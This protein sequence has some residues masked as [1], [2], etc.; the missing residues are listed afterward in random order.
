MRASKNLP[1]R[2][3]GGPPSARCPLSPQEI[4]DKMAVQAATVARIDEMRDARRSEGRHTVYERPG[5]RG[6][7][8]GGRG[9]GGIRDGD[10]RRPLIGYTAED[11]GFTDEGCRGPNR[12]LP[13]PCSIPGFF[14]THGAS[15]T[16]SPP[17]VLVENVVLSDAGC[18]VPTRSSSS[19]IRHP[20]SPPSSLP[21]HPAP[22]G[23]WGRVP[24]RRGAGRHAVLLCGPTGR[25]GPHVPVLPPVVPQPLRR[26]RRPRSNSKAVAR[27]GGAGC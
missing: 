27:G 21:T 9:G 17:A 5:Q 15:P 10:S 26:Q 12:L 3:G 24:A 19:T 22:P 18:P 13:P 7:V 25:G 8:G 16:R 6:P 14:P 11:G 2:G 1:R 4:A 20:T 23:W